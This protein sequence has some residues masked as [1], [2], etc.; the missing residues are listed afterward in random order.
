MKYISGLT[1]GRKAAPPE[2]FSTQ[3]ITRR[4]FSTISFITIGESSSV[5]KIV[6]KPGCEPIRT[7]STTM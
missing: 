7:L 5:R 1:Q 2:A 4:P 3:K 6:L